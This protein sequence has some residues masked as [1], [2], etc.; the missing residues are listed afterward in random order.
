M[1]DLPDDHL[2]DT[3]NEFCARVRISRR[4]FYTLLERGEAPPIIRIGRRRLIRRATAEAWLRAR[5]QTAA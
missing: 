2:A 4:T 3:I 5:E 1:T